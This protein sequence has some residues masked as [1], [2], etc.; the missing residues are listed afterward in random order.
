MVVLLSPHLGATDFYV[1]QSGDDSARGVSKES[2][3]KSIERVNGTQLSPGDRVLF[4]GGQHF[5]G[6]LR[7]TGEDA[8]T[9]DAPVIIGSFGSGPAWLDAG[10]GTGIS[11]ESAGGIRIENLNI[12]GAGRTNNHGYG[13]LCDNKQPGDATL[14]C[15]QIDRVQVGG[16]GVFGILISGDQGGYE[17]VRVT[18]CIL[19]EN[20]RG[21]MEIAGRLA[22][23]ATNYAHANVEVIRCQ[24]YDNSGDPN[25]LKNHSGS[26]M[27]LYQVNGGLIDHCQA[28][29][30]GA[31][32]RSKTGGGVGIWT[33]ASRNV[34][35]QHCESFGN[36]TSGAD[37]G[38]FDIDGGSIDCTLQYNYSH[39]NDG[40]GL[41]VYTYPYASYQDRGSVVRFNISQNDSR[42]SRTYAGLYVRSY[43]PPV[44]GLEVYNNTIIVGPWCDQAAFVSGENVQARFQNNIFLGAQGAVPLRVEAS[45]DGIQFVNNLLWS[46]GSGPAVVW[47][48]MTNAP[49]TNGMIALSQAAQTGIQRLLWQPPSFTHST[50]LSPT[51]RLGNLAALRFFRPTPPSLAARAGLNLS[52]LY[53]N[54]GPP[55]DFMGNVLTGESSWPVG[56]IGLGSDGAP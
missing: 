21:G 24:A 12:Q 35:I 39:D 30:N 17:N 1:A 8:G 54:H 40:P 47:D 56:A 19:R 50:S 43:G 25:Y 44:S 33:C 13:I 5:T 14:K 16:F 18:D 38:G 3:W 26:G 31:E 55:R 28:W 29:N 2:A 32:C 23:T 11:V 53:R 7:L 6:N 20:L 49:G 41:M 52:Q 46:D 45:N 15:L 10:T 9:C 4:E 34:V 27:V 51:P 42:R 36:R 37:G 48:G 22:V